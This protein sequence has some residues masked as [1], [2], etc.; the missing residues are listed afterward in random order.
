MIGWAV[1]PD[2]RLVVYLARCLGGFIVVLCWLMI[3]AAMVP[4][5]M[6]V[7]FEAMLA[8]WA[9]MLLIHVWGAVTGAQPLIETL[10][11]GV[12]A[13][14]ILLTLAFWPQTP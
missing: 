3:R 14:V 11:I 2:T 5:A 13:G 9:V 6:P 8:L 12:W 4:E 10:E 7:V 1:P